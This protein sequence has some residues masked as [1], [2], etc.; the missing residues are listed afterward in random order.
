MTRSRQSIPYPAI[1]FKSIESLGQVAKS[2]ISDG[3]YLGTVGSIVRWLCVYFFKPAV[4]FVTT[5]SGG[6]AAPE[7]LVVLIRKR[8]PS[9]VTSY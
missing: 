5:V 2:G 6:D 3:C 9:A 7:P 4:Q 1:H 8:L